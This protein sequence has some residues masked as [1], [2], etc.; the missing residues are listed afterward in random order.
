MT[1]RVQESYLPSSFG[2]YTSEVPCYV[3]TNH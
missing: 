3:Y 1:R 2:L